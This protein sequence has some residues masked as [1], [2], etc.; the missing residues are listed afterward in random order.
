MRWV[1]RYGKKGKLSPRFICSFEIL[2]MIGPVAYRIVQRPNLSAVN[3][4]FH[5]SMLWKYTPDPSHV[6]DHD[7]V[8]LRDDLTYKEDPIQI[9]DKKESND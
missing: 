2:E 8:F 7:T 3:N 9:I 5:V 6:L 1:L 4:I